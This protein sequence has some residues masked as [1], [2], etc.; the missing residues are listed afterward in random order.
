MIGEPRDKRHRRIVRAP[1]LQ[2]TV[3]MHKL[4][5]ARQVRLKGKNLEAVAATA[6][7]AAPIASCI[8]AVN[9]ISGMF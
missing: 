2:F 9:E 4:T 3:L 6:L 1:F 8:R 7:H 5:G